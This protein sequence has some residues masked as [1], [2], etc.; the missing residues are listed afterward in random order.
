LGAAGGLVFAVLVSIACAGSL[1][2]NIFTTGRF[3]ESA[4]HKGYIPKFWGVQGW[5]ISSEESTPSTP[6]YGTTSGPP[7]SPQKPLEGAARG[8]PL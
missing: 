6:T 8:T 4:A 1:N 5:G 7:E 2:A 3:T